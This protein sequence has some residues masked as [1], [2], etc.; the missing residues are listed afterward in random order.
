VV[1]WVTVIVAIIGLIGTVLGGTALNE[2]LKRRDLRESIKSDVEVWK[3]IPDSNAREKLRESIERRVD[4]LAVEKQDFPWL[5]VGFLTFTSVV[6]ILIFGTIWAN[7]GGAGFRH[8]E[9]GILRWYATT[10]ESVSF[11][12]FVLSVAAACLI[13]SFV[14]YFL[15]LATESAVAVGRERLKAW[16][17]ALGQKLARKLRR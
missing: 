13:A 17:E 8:D 12:R 6:C 5:L 16:A 7:G 2:W 14:T 11:Q 1:V 15:Q 9:H 4:R 10:G 3:A